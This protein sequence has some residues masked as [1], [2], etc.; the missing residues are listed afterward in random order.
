MIGLDH[1]V[2]LPDIGYILNC[3]PCEDPQEI[4]LIRGLVQRSRFNA[5][6]LMLL[7]Q[8]TSPSWH[9]LFPILSNAAYLVLVIDYLRY[10][11][12]KNGRM[13]SIYPVVYPV[14]WILGPFCISSIYHICD[15]RFFCFKI[16]FD[17][18]HFADVYI[19]F[20]CAIYTLTTVILREQRFFAMLCYIDSFVSGQKQY[21][22]S[23]E[24]IPVIHT[25]LLGYM[26]FVSSLLLHFNRTNVYIIGILFSMVILVPV[27]PLVVCKYGNIEICSE[28]KSSDEKLIIIVQKGSRDGTLYHRKLW[29]PIGLFGVGFSCFLLSQRVNPAPPPMNQNA[30]SPIDCNQ[31]PSGR[32]NG[33]WY[34]VLHS[35]WHIASAISI[36]T[37][38]VC[39]E[40]NSTHYEECLEP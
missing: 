15:E 28:A 20:I 6:F 26:T 19:G 18:L 5:Y 3:Y 38:L 36:R 34:W 37:L 35:I 30:S 12:R 22:L 17:S 16:S 39:R 4:Q 31:K 33:P 14:L 2:T 32:V 23:S 29:L 8:T 24:D 13:H 7:E 9:G 21:V 11:T 10:G 40:W 27:L 1:T 25:C